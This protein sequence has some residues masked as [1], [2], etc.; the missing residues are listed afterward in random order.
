MEQLKL[1]VTAAQARSTTQTDVSAQSGCAQGR[2]DRGSPANYEILQMPQ[3]P[4]KSSPAHSSPRAGRAIL[5]PEGCPLRR[6]PQ[7]EAQKQQQLFIKHRVKRGEMPMEQLNKCALDIIALKWT[8]LRE[9]QNLLSWDKWTAL[10][11]N[12]SVG[13]RPR[14]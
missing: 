11:V 6:K 2:G 7:R 4:A 9:K 10:L 1:S 14:I 13:L 3:T 12:Q 5:S 8:G